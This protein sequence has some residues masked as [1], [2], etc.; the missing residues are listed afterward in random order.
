MRIGIVVL[1]DPVGNVN[2]KSEGDALL[3]QAQALYENKKTEN[4]DNTI[5]I[6]TEDKNSQ[7]P[8]TNLGLYQSEHAALEEIYLIAHSD[9]E[10]IETRGETL[11][12]R[13]VAKQFLD[14]GKVEEKFKEFIENTFLSKKT[15]KPSMNLSVHL[16][17][18]ETGLHPG[19]QSGATGANAV[20]PPPRSFG[21]K[22]CRGLV[23]R[24][25]QVLQDVSR[26]S[27]TKND[28]I[29]SRFEINIKVEALRGWNA[30]MPDGSSFFYYSD[31]AREKRAYK[32][33][34][35]IYYLK[36]ALTSAEFVLPETGK[37]QNS[38]I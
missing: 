30:V 29:A 38:N 27:E 11:N 15:P 21:E 33:T 1:T 37:V 5:S 8:F 16:Y 17:A 6:F 19:E 13:Q 32:E 7:N 36:R 24:M 4:P 2:R 25:G 12:V 3:K 34:S 26:T 14:E 35:E 22:L 23:T 28:Y 18:C 10:V 9:G 20:L 31:S